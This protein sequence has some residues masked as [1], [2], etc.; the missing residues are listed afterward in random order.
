[1]IPRQ[2][3]QL[4]RTLAREFKVVAITGPR[5]TGKTTLA[6]AVFGDRPYV[7]LE[8]PDQR[9]FAE[10]DPR[11]FLELYPDGAVIDEAQRCPDLF[12]YLQGVVDGRPESG[13]FILTGSH[14]RLVQGAGLVV[15]PGRCGGR[16]AV[17]GL[18]RQTATA[19]RRSR[20]VALEPDRGTGRNNLRFKR[21]VSVWDC[22]PFARS[23]CSFSAK[24]ESLA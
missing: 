15:R 21:S 4:A 24:L 16:S 17:A 18:R 2:S 19:A 11:R 6:R 9:L 7:N 12:S 22:L 20:G 5:Q 23:R 10:E 14:H 3:E 1:M 8:E 13:Q